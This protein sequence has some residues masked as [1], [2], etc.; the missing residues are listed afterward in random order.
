MLIEGAPARRFG[1]S[2]SISLIEGH[3]RDLGTFS[4]AR[5]LPAATRR[6]VGPF[7]FFDHMGPVDFAPGEGVSVRPHPHIGLATVTYLFEGAMTHRDSIGSVQDIVPGDVNWMSAGR[8]VVHSERSPSELLA[9]GHRVHGL[10]IW[11]ALPSQEEQSAPWF[12]HHRKESL[13]EL[14]QPGVT[15]RIIVGS[16]FGLHAPIQHSVPMFYAHATMDAHAELAFPAEYAERGVYPVDASVQVDGVF[17]TPRTMAVV[18]S[19]SPVTIRAQAKAT[20]MLFGGAA[21][22]GERFLNWNF[23]A[24]SKDLIAAARASW[25]SYPNTQFPK[26]PGDDEWIPLPA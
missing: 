10:Q 12:K 8:G 4:V 5:I 14:S 13:P 7:V 15:L 9:R 19:A 24:T 18:D 3:V 6:H 1:W 23:V 16:A 17:A 26:V 2:M 21:V 25:S 20:V 22:D 11:V